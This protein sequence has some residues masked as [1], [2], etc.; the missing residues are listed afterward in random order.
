MSLFLLWNGLQ[1]SK[2]FLIS[3]AALDCSLV[4]LQGRVDCGS[5]AG[6]EDSCVEDGCCY[7]I[8][9]D[10]SIPDCYHPAGKMLIFQGVLW[11]MIFNHISLAWEGSL[12]PWGCKALIVIHQKMVSFRKHRAMGKGLV[13]S[14]ECNICVRSPAWTGWILYQSMDF[15]SLSMIRELIR[16][17]LADLVAQLLITKNVGHSLLIS[18]HS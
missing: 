7:E 3:V 17:N 9:N 18:A 4:P 1:M 10:P 15:V 2:S 14:K 13:H 8:T 6:T 16:D 12:S 5:I 11:R